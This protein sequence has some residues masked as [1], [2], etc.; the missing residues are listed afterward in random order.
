MTFFSGNPIN[1]ILVG[2]LH[3]IMSLL[4]LAIFDLLLII[5]LPALLGLYALLVLRN[6]ILTLCFPVLPLRSSVL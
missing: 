3:F 2:K 5:L 6:A 4:I 1:F